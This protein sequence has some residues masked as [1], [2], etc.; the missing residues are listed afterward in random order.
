MASPR[1]PVLCAAAGFILAAL[2]P[3]AAARAEP[4]NEFTAAEVRAEFARNSYTAETPI[5]WWTAEA[6]HTEEVRVQRYPDRDALSQLVNGHEISLAIQV[7][8]ALGAADLLS[9]GRLDVQRV[10][11]ATHVHPRC[12]NGRAPWTVSAFS[13]T[14]RSAR[15]SRTPR[16]HPLRSGVPGSI[17]AWAMMVGG[18]C[19]V[20]LGRPARVRSVGRVPSA[21]CGEL[22]HVGRSHR[23]TGDCE[24]V[25]H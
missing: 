7:A 2:P 19:V 12:I 16:A 5:A 21:N 1:W 4:P 24:L 6:H 23:A 17:R 10:S 15:F 3:V 25:R 18:P 20:Q 11:A 8:A 13:R 22:S 14:I 9:D